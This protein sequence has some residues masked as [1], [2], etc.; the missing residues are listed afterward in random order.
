M[1]AGPEVVRV[2]MEFEE[3]HL[4]TSPNESKR[5][6]IATMTSVLQYKIPSSQMSGP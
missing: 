4:S 3:D 6:T 5:V 2:L 1:G